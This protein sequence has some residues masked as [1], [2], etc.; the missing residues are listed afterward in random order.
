MR[1]HTGADAS[2]APF[3]IYLPLFLG[4]AW[5]ETS[6][7]SRFRILRCGVL[8]VS[9]DP[10][11][12]CAQTVLHRYTRLHSIAFNM[13]VAHWA[14][15]IFE[16][17][18]AVRYIAGTLN[19]DQ[20]VPKD[21]RGQPVVRPGSLGYGLFWSYIIHHVRSRAGHSHVG[22]VTV[23]PATIRRRCPAQNYDWAIVRLYVSEYC[24]K[25]L[26]G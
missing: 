10:P 15:T 9:A 16:D 20:L 13:A 24:D 1:E 7:L 25:N 5:S 23:P 19:E 18:A 21:A 11:C 26:F 12:P 8:P 3:I 17:A 6:S 14:F 2:E 22:V 4:S